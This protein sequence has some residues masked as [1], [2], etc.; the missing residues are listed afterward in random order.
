[1]CIR[2][3][4][5]KILLRVLFFFMLFNLSGLSY[6]LIKNRYRPLKF[7]Y[8][9][10]AEGRTDS[11]FSRDDYSKIKYLYFDLGY[12]ICD[13]LDD[14]VE[15]NVYNL[16]EMEFEVTTRKEMIYICSYCVPLKSYEYLPGNNVIGGG[17]DNRATFFKDK[18]QEG[19]C[20]FYEAEDINPGRMA[21]E[22]EYADM[23]G[24]LERISVYIILF[25]FAGTLVTGCLCCHKK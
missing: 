7:S 15:R 18:Y 11:R 21:L 12:D 9:G 5:T 4:I 24:Q 10:C 17:T 8:L 16:E 14:L 19:M 6:L 25:F 20:F 2:K 1:M 22:G 23:D 3:V 13:S